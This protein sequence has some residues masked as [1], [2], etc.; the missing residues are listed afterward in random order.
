MFPGDDAIVDDVN[1]GLRKIAMFYV[2]ISKDI[3]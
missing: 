1:I 2:V 3:T